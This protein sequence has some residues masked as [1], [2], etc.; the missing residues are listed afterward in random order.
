MRYLFIFNDGR[1]IESRGY[2]LA[3]ETIW[4]VRPEGP[5]KVGLP[6]LD[7]DATRRELEQRG[8]EFPVT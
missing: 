2:V 8:I 6:E 4:I 3:G 5:M 1:R 7:V